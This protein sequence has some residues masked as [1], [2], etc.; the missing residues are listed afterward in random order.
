LINS[1]FRFCGAFS[2]SAF[3]GKAYN[4]SSG[5]IILKSLIV[6]RTLLEEKKKDWEYSWIRPANVVSRFQVWKVNKVMQF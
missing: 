2:M 6:R 4:K 1:I 5:S 3:K